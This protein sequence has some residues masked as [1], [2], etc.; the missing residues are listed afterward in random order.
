MTRAQH[1]QLT[2]RLLGNPSIRL[3]V[4]FE[5][6]LQTGESRQAGVDLLLDGP[7]ASDPGPMRRL[8]G[9]LSGRLGT[10]VRVWPLSTAR[11]AAILMLQV[12]RCGVVLKDLD[13]MWRRLE[14][15]RG[16]IETEAREHEDWERQRIDVVKT[17]VGP[18]A[19]VHLAIDVEPLVEGPRIRDGLTLVLGCADESK[20]AICEI[21]R[22]LHA[23][24]FHFTTYRLSEVVAEPAVLSHCLL[25][26]RVLKD[27]RHVWGELQKK[28]AEVVAS[29]RT[30][31][32]VAMAARR[33]SRSLRGSAGLN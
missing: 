3:A 12:L 16:R 28:Q 24:S 9:D 1:Q 18:D 7:T 6:V 21:H 33:R 2:A 15:E 17:V 22:K 11:P 10:P 27:A 20:G 25:T 13:G 32:A 23:S 29:S 14:G 31:Q 8:V 19:N 4:A 30:A 5:R 26:G